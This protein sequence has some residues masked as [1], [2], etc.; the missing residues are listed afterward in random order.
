MD[1]FKIQKQFSGLYNKMKW[2]YFARNAQKDFKARLSGKVS[3]TKEEKRRID[4]F[5][6]PYTN[7]HPVFHTFYKEKLGDVRP[8]YIPT[9]IYVN[10]ID[11]YF[12]DRKA[13]VILDNKCLYPRLFPGIP[14]P[15]IIVCR[16]GGLWYDGDMQRITEEKRDALLNAEPSIF[17]KA[18]TDSFGGKGVQYLDVKDGPLAEQFQKMWAL[19]GMW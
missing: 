10:H 6:A 18:A 17:V 16:M 4:A 19:R 13:S 2:A 3:L 12:N 5:W 1:M 7:V 9:D 14:Q 11:A 8:E 15:T